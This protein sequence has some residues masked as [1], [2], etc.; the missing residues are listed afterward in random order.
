[1]I[2]NQI[3]EVNKK[4]IYNDVNIMLR[5]LSGDQEAWHY[6]NGEE[7]FYV[8]DVLGVLGV[9]YPED[10][11]FNINVMFDYLND[12][13]V[14]SG[15]RKHTIIVGNSEVMFS[16]LIDKKS[17]FMELFEKI[18]YNFDDIAVVTSQSP[19]K[20]IDMYLCQDYF[21]FDELEAYLE[22]YDSNYRFR[23]VNEYYDNFVFLSV[24]AVVYAEIDSEI[25]KLVISKRFVET[26]DGYYEY[27]G[28]KYPVNDF[29][30]GVKYRFNR[31]NI[32]S[33]SY[34]ALTDVYDQELV[35]RSLE[36]MRQ[37]NKKIIELV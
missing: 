17:D 9:E 14:N 20:S 25:K 34:R 1:M 16:Q 30:T 2:R 23:L 11:A 33:I 10:W 36:K 12:F 15:Y 22:N 31:N 35:D 37:K 27:E 32:E 5:N 26:E 24:G 13:F 8:A 19:R 7:I 6:I 4:Q 3:I 29:E 28:M 21:D 18:V